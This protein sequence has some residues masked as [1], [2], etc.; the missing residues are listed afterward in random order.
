MSVD[1]GPAGRPDRPT[2]LEVLS[3]R[4]A[5]LEEAADVV[6]TSVVE[7]RPEDLDH[8]LD[9]KALSDLRDAV[10]DLV[11]AVTQARWWLRQEPDPARCLPGLHSAV[12]DAGQALHTDLLQVDRRFDLARRAARAWG[13][14]WLPWTGVV[15]T[16]LVETAD[17]LS[18]A[19]RSLVEAWTSVVRTPPAGTA[20]PAPSAPPAPPAASARNQEAQR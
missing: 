1:L 18:R 6:R 20:A 3:E 5:A 7:D 15:H 12:L 17:S 11:D 14:T 8:D 4:L 10:D 2:P 9:H 16:N 19:E 13:G